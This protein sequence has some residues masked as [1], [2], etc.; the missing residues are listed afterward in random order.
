MTLTQLRCS[1]AESIIMG[2]LKRFVLAG[3]IEI[4]YTFGLEIP[5]VAHELD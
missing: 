1:N 2:K 4:I 3:V 5:I